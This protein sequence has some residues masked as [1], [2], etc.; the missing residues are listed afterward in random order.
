M[1][2]SHLQTPSDTNGNTVTTDVSQ[3]SKMEDDT[4]K[5]S[6]ADSQENSTQV[7]DDAYQSLS[8]VRT[9]PATVSTIE[10]EDTVIST[11]DEISNDATNA[12]DEAEDDEL[13][14]SDKL[15]KIKIPVGG[16][17]TVAYALYDFE[18]EDGELSFKVRHADCHA[19]H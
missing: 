3:E 6:D 18:G 16:E 2:L 19:F 7:M 14:D 17:E 8:E 12:I 9:G 13:T 5:V 4:T 1:F 15:D 10:M 11:K